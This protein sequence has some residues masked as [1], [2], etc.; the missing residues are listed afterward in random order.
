M[1]VLFTSRSVQTATGAKLCLLG[2]PH[3]QSLLWGGAYFLPTCQAG[4][5]SI[6]AQCRLAEKVGRGVLVALH[7]AQCSKTQVFTLVAAHPCAELH[8][9]DGIL[10]IPIPTATPTAAG[11]P[12]ASSD[13]TS[14]AP[15]QPAPALLP[16]PHANRPCGNVNTLSAF[17]CTAGAGIANPF[18]SRNMCG[19][20]IQQSPA[21]F[22]KQM[23]L[24]GSFAYPIYE[25]RGELLLLLKRK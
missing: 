13:S 2:M 22:L 16:P 10:S 7:M 4:L 9:P 14:A 18:V 24:A 20:W 15:V 12:G 5:G 25:K 17:I 19:I 23:L 3:L 8:F 21:L 1:V 11:A 6:P